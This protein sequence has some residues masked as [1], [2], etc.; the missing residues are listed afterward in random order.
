MATTAGD[1]RDTTISYALLDNL[2]FRRYAGVAWCQAGDTIRKVRSSG[3]ALKTQTMVRVSTRAL[4]V[5]I[6]VLFVAVGRY[7]SLQ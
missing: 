1:Y 7:D 4:T 3:K 5:A 6:Y 2:D